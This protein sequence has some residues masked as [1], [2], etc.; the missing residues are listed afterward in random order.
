MGYGMAWQA[1][2]LLENPFSGFWLC[3][4]A[5]VFLFSSALVP[6]LLDN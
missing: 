3:A 4:L 1:D 2:N 6:G 5:F